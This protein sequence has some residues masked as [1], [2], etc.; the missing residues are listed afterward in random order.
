MGVRFLNKLINRYSKNGTKKI[1]LFTLRDKVVVI[2]ISI[3]L[4]KFASSN[5]L[6]ENIYLL[7][8]ILQFYGIKPICIFDGYTPKE[9]KA[10]ILKRR[11]R[12]KEAQITYNNLKNIINNEKNVNKI[13]QLKKK[14]R[15][16]R[17]KFVT[18]SYKDR[19]QVKQLLELMRIS[20]YQADGEA[21]ELCAKL[22][23]NG[24]AYACLSEDTDLFVYGCPYVLRYISL[25]N[26]TAVLY[27]IDMILQDLG[28]NLHDFQKICVLSGT[29]YKNEKGSHNIFH[30]YKQYKL[31]NI[32]N[33]NEEYKKIITMFQLDNKD[34]SKDKF[35]SNEDLSVD[36]KLLHTFLEDYGF[37]YP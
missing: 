15:N 17:R 12:K 19:L 7:C 2:D 23:L 37:I 9:K 8:S 4:Y 32:P 18:V 13:F 30:N 22:V 33:L 5:T 3:Y 24:E 27:N 11:E 6:I 25:K 1:S 16:L 29:D 35:Y 28:M 10:E 21:D 26:H 36:K 34:I 14:M 31:N 20:Y